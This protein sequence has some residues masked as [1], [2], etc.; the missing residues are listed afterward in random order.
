MKSSSIKKLLCLCTVLLLSACVTAPDVVKTADNNYSMSRLDR[1][2]SMSDIAAT[3]QS[4]IAD[5]NKFAEKQGQLAVKI[6]M[7]DTP[8]QVPGFTTVE[9]KFQLMSK[10]A[11]AAMP[12]ATNSKVQ[13][14]AVTSGSN[15]LS[16]SNAVYDSL[17]KL[18]E[19]HKRGI[20]TDEEFSSQKKKILNSN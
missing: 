3:R 9:Y 7:L 1:G 14:L 8:T 18:D 20:L 13:G 10:E 15:E 12:V 17:I 2:G 5:A 11:V 6:A 4:L 19:L 16:R